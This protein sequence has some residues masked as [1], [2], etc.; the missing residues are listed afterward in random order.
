[1]SALIAEPLAVASGCRH[2]LQNRWYAT[3]AMAA[4]KSFSFHKRLLL[5]LLAHGLKLLRQQPT[6]RIFR[7]AFAFNALRTI[8]AL[9]RAVTTL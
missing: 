4:S 6:S 1:M 5:P 7:V 2:S 9:H 8:F 3:Y